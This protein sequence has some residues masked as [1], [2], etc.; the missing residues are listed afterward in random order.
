MLWVVDR[1]FQANS[2]GVLG[3]AW[4]FWVVTRTFP[5]SCYSILGSC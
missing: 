4:V 5:F 2:K 3:G 1:A